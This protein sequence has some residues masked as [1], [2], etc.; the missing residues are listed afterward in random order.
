M[1]VAKTLD[2]C[3]FCREPINP[4]ATRCKHCHAD[5][6]PGEKTR[7]PFR[8]LNNFRAGFLSG[9]L[10]CLILTVLIYLQFYA[11]D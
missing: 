3:P 2:K 8:K 10:F 11:G 5:L 1:S 9:V 7:S 6:K 4:G